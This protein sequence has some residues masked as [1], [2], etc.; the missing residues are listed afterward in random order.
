MPFGYPILQ[1]VVVIASHQNHGKANWSERP[2]VSVM[3]IRRFLKLMTDRDYA[4]KSVR[5][6]Y[7]P[8]GKIKYRKDYPGSYNPKEKTLY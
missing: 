5:R 6:N 7:L 2:P 1:V 8:D 3:M 4:I